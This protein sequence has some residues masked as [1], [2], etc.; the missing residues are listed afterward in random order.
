MIRVLLLSLGLQCFAPGFS[1]SAFADSTGNTVLIEQ[2]TAPQPE[3][4]PRPE[5][6]RFTMRQLYIP[7]LLAVGGIAANRSAENS[8][9][10]KV[11]GYRNR[12][13]SGFKTHVDDYL[14][15]SP[16]LAAYSLD[17]VGIKSKTDYMN[18]TLILLKGEILM[19][20][21][22]EILKRTTKVTRPDGSDAKSFPSGHTAQAFAGATF[23]S[24][25]YGHRYKWMPFAAYGVASTVGLLRMANNKHYISDVLLGAGIGYLSVKLAY[26]THQ[27][28]WW[29]KKPGTQRSTA[30][31]H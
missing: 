19:A 28:K 21:T 11:A 12:Q 1:Q 25:E 24:E 30:L 6:L 23:L 15:F 9:K 22:V 26:W 3:P 13:M 27:Y 31:M 20:A 17:G 5:R 16:I 7:A 18:R 8:L 2:A 29:Q 4:L 10:N 14:V